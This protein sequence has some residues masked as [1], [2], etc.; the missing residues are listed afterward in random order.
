MYGGVFFLVFFFLFVLPHGTF[1][2]GEL[3][4]FLYSWLLALRFFLF[5][6]FNVCWCVSTLLNSGPEVS[7]EALFFFRKGWFV[8]GGCFFFTVN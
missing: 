1:L 2:F 3:Y 7:G 6:F 5:F 4:F 8:C